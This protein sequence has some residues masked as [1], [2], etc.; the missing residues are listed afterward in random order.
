VAQAADC[1]G[2]PCCA[3]TGDQSPNEPSERGA[4]CHGFCVY[5]P[6]QKAQLD[7]PMALAPCDFAAILPALAEA[8]LAA[9]PRWQRGCDPAHF[10]SPLRLHLLHQIMLI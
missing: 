3:N 2:D 5:V 8:Q 4:E 1:C 9:G 6:A 10:E 7:A